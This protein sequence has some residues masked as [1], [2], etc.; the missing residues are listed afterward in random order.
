MPQKRKEL[1]PQ[2]RSRICELKSIGWGAQRIHTKHRD[3]P[4]ST[5]KT[6]LRL[7]KERHNNVSK[8]RSGRPHKLT[9]N[10]RDH[11]YE[12]TVLDPHIKIRSLIDEVDGTVKKRSIQRLLYEMDRRKW[13]QRERPEIKECHAI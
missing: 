11:I 8:P 5:I 1:D 13:V 2:T 10:Q 6:T 12:C 3:I 4:L 7:E 9:E